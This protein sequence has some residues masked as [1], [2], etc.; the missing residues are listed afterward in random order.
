M[1]ES[2]LVEKEQTRTGSAESFEFDSARAH[3]ETFTT[4]RAEIV[5]GQGG[6][7]DVRRAA[8]SYDV[9]EPHSRPV[10]QAG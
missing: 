9:T 4:A 1:M 7:A 6:V 8:E 5:F 2:E 3:S 10:R